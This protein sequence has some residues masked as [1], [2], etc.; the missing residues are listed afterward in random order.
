M[1]FI[2]IKGYHYYYKKAG[3]NKGKF[4]LVFIHGSGGYHHIWSN[5]LEDFSW[6]TELIVP[7]LPGHGFSE[8]DGKNTIE[9]Y[10]E[11]LKAFLSGLCIK[12]CVLIGHSMGGAIAQECVLRYPDYFRGL[13]LVATGAKL[14]V[15]PLLINL[16]NKNFELMAR[17]CSAYA[18]ADTTPASVINEGAK[19][20]LKN[21]PEILYKDFMACDCFDCRN[22]I[23]KIKI[24]TLIVC[25]NKDLLTPPKYS[26]YLH[27]RI[28]NS[29]LHI[30][31]GAGHM[32]MIESSYKFNE[33]VK[34]FCKNLL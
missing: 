29:S 20:L 25:G 32:V 34:N 3:L 24:P 8:D 27:E 15:S 4:Q 31:E 28:T 18:Y 1:P 16:L 21:N 14:R 6:D 11:W 13:V 33:I 9:E 30:I 7:D 22:R 12:N 23:H 17:I 26:L 19:I 2:L 10:V 5:Q